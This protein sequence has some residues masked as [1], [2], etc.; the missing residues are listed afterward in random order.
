MSLLLLSTGTLSAQDTAQI[1]LDSLA[2]SVGETAE[3]A[4]R[5]D[6][7][8]S[9][10]TAFE[11]ELAVDRPRIVRLDDVALGG[12][13]G[14]GA[15]EF[16]K[17]VDSAAGTLFFAAAAIGQ[18]GEPDDNVLFTLTV[19]ALQQGTATIRVVDIQIG[20][21]EPL[22]TQVI[23]GIVQVRQV[24]ATSTPRPTPTQQP[25]PEPTRVVDCLGTLPS[26]LEPGDWA[27]VTPGDPN[28][29]RARPD[30]D[31]NRVGRIPA[32]GEFLV[33]E[34]PECADGYAWYR[35]NYAGA[36]GWT[37]EGDRS[38]YWLVEIQKT[39]TANTIRARSNA[40]Y[41]GFEGGTMVWLELNDQIYV[42]RNNGDY[43]VFGDYFQEGQVEAAGNY[44][45]P[46]LRFVP[47]RGFGIVWH[48]RADVR[49]ALSWGLHAEVGYQTGVEY[50]L[51]D[52][53]VTFG[54]PDGQTFVLSESGRW[55]FTSG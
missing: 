5:V 52:G 51:R 37:A 23:G 32:E 20:D 25:T 42:L 40:A 36:V 21:L 34:G 2:L 38:G 9:A 44:D 31:S 43:E 26:R 35:V 17:V 12:Y 33:L 55:Q 53:W 45:P 47:V 10:C 1:E 13:L 14:D 29:L 41:Q 54:G 3:L 49:A 6:C 8:Q 16:S 7:G 48:N 28:T 39:G 22:P 11:V 24:R 50:S 15:Q 4:I 18:A 27:Q 19:T 46:A 30:I